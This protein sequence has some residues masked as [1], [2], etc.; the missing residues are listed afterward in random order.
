MSI[1]QT[2]RFDEKKSHA[3]DIQGWRK[4]IA[5]YTSNFVYLWLTKQKVLHMKKEQKKKTQQNVWDELEKQIH[6]WHKYFFFYFWTLLTKK[7]GQNNFGSTNRIQ[8]TNW[9]YLK[10]TSS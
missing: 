3:N 9:L 10:G 5:S 7:T 6:E 1:I 2:N 4:K 8:K